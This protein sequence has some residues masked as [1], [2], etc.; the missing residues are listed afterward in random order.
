MNRS[1]IK[2]LVTLVLPAVVLAIVGS[3]T[4]CDARARTSAT[5]YTSVGISNSTVVNASGD[6]DL[7]QIDKPPATTKQSSRIVLGRGGRLSP[8]VIGLGWTGRIWATLY[9]KAAF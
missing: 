2:L 3:T 4:L 8:A 6:P 9:L 1:R 5:A 7:P